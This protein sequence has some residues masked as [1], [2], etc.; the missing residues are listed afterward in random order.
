MGSVAVGK[1][2]VNVAP[3]HGP[4][5]GSNTVYKGTHPNKWGVCPRGDGQSRTADQGL[6]PLP[7]PLGY[8]APLFTFPRP[9]APSLGP[10]AAV[11]S[12][13][14]SP[15]PFTADRVS[16]RTPH[17][18]ALPFL[19]VTGRSA[20]VTHH[21]SLRSTASLSRPAPFFQKQYST[22][23]GTAATQQLLGFL[24]EGAIHSTKRIAMHIIL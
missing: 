6:R 23:K 7:S 19:R 8:V 18:R 20:G 10:L 4:H 16:A 12:Q 1:R 21:A 5:C 3:L 13:G 11:S 24:P 15:H 22:S 9:G 17:L 14:A 2:Q